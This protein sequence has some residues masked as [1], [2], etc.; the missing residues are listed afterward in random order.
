MHT[1][2]LGRTGASSFTC[3]SG[4]CSPVS[5]SG[6]NGCAVAT[7]TTRSAGSSPGPSTMPNATSP[8]AEN[9]AMRTRPR[10]PVRGRCELGSNGGGLL[11]PPRQ[12]GGVGGLGPPEQDSGAEQAQLELA[13]EP[14]RRLDP[15]ALQRVPVELDRLLLAGREPVAVHCE[16]PRQVA[17]AGPCSGER[18][19]QQDRA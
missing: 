4:T 18:P 7:E 15:V 14:A 17:T 12:L 2:L 6:A 11:R 3:E 13:L 5:W 8:E 10:L 9:R 19:V 1:T 16:V